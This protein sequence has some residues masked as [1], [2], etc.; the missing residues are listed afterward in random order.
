MR[1]GKDIC[2]IIHILVCVCLEDLKGS[3]HPWP[4]EATVTEINA[5]ITTEEKMADM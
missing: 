3:N 4:W 5:E 1:N 2:I